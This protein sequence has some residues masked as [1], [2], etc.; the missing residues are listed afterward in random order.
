MTKK[1]ILNI[2][3]ASA[4]LATLVAIGAMFAT[5]QNTLSRALGCAGFIGLM[6]IGSFVVGV[7]YPK[8]ENGT[9][10]RINRTA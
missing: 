3:V 7:V 2:S 1:Q 10:S 5:S 4:G 6:S 9:E 8:E